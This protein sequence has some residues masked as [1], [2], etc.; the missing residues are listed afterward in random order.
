MILVVNNLHRYWSKGVA[1]PVAFKESNQFMKHL[2]ARILHWFI[3]ASM[4][5]AGVYLLLMLAVVVLGD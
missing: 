1:E 3:V 4:A 2:I 5:M